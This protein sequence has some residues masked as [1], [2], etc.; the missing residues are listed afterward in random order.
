MVQLSS[1]GRV[2]RLSLDG[3]KV[4]RLAEGGSKAKAHPLP[5]G[6][7]EE[8]RF[9]TAEWDRTPERAASKCDFN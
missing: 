2:L 1:S 8:S 9:R 4:N 7:D 5:S 3:V 6:V